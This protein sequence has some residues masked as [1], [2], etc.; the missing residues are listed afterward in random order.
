MKCAPAVAKHRRSSAREAPLVGQHANVSG[1]KPESAKDRSNAKT[2]AEK[3]EAL[4]DRRRH[5]V[6]SL[7]STKG[8]ALSCL[9][10]PLE[11]WSG[12]ESR[13]QKIPDYVF[14]FL[15]FGRLSSAT[16][17]DPSPSVRRKLF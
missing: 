17:A 2:D 7:L 15:A 13:R 1:K 4:Q 14:W 10:S 11:K 16:P 12:P 6:S 3:G 5:I 8:R 9:L